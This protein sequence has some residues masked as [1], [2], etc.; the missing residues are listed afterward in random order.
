MFISESIV[1]QSSYVKELTLLGDVDNP[2]VRSIEHSRNRSEEQVCLELLEHTVCGN[3]VTEQTE[4]VVCLCPSYIHELIAES[5]EDSLV[6][7]LLAHKTQWLTSRAKN[8]CSVCP[9]TNLGNC[10]VEA[11]VVLNLIDNLDR[12]KAI[13]VNNRLQNIALFGP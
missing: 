2:T 4:T 11:L 5:I 12:R 10:S 3:H 9:T 6:E 7:N 1:I 8:D 13:E